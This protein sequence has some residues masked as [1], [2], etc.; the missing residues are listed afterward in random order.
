MLCNLDD[1]GLPELESGMGW[2]FR[3]M[4]GRVDTGSYGL[5]GSVN[6]V[7]SQKENSFEVFEHA[8]EHWNAVSG[9]C[10]GNQG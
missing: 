3:E 7:R 6:S 10:I 1:E 5:V 9:Y 4:E 2:Q 8:K